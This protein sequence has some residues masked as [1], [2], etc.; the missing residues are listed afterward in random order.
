MLAPN[1]KLRCEINRDAQKYAPDIAKTQGDDPL[2]S[3]PARISW[4]RLLKRVFEFD[5]ELCPHFN[6]SAVVDYF[7]AGIV[8]LGLYFHFS[9]R[10]WCKSFRPLAALTPIY[11]RFSRFQTFANKDKCIS[12]NACTTVCHQRID[13]ISF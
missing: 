11:A 3:V 4:A 12:C 1:A 8:G 13:I 10:T 9:G 6:Y 2:P 5:L 7:L